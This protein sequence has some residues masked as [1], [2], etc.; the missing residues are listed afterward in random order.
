MQK[1]GSAVAADLCGHLSSHAPHLPCPSLQITMSI[2]SRVCGVGFCVSKSASSER[3]YQCLV[4]TKAS[5][6]CTL[7]ACWCVDCL[8]AGPVS[9]DNDWCI[10]Q[11]AVKTMG[12]ALANS[13][14][15]RYHSQ[16]L[17]QRTYHFSAVSLQQAMLRLE[18]VR[19]T[20]CVLPAGLS[21]GDMLEL[22]IDTDVKGY[23]A[24]CVQVCLLDNWCTQKRKA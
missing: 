21:I 22:A 3:G 13:S 10:W 9:K 23:C 15:Q 20:C 14:A 18:C 7:L 5:C 19:T 11:C 2:L 6:V 17:S 12:D 4:H 16:D 1:S 8:D 24:G